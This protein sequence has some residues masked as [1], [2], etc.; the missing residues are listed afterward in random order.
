MYS[1]QQAPHLY[2]SQFSKDENAYLHE[3]TKLK[4]VGIEPKEYIRA[5]EVLANTL[6]EAF[7]TG[8]SYEFNA[9]NVNKHTPF[10]DP[11]KSS[12]L[13]VTGDTDIT[14]RSAYDKNPFKIPIEEFNSIFHTCEWE[15]LTADVNNIRSWHKVSASAMTAIT[16]ELIEIEFNGKTI[17]CTPS[18]KILTKNRGWVEAENLNESDELVD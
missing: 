6:T 15:V 4:D 5:Q 9:T 16:T 13:C 18:H 11:I 8:R 14:V 12:N 3:L 1:Y 2:W 10:K 7:E 17:R